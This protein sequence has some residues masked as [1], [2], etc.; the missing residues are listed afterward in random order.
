MRCVVIG[1]GGHANVVVDA[2]LEE[3][4][5]GAGKWNPIGVLDDDAS[6]RD[7][8]GDIPY[9]GAVDDLDDVEHDGV[10]LA[11]G[12][13]RTRARLYDE[14]SSRGETFATAIHPASTLA[15]SVSIGDGTLVCAGVVVNPY[16][17][18]G[19]NVILNTSC[20]VDHHCRIE[21]DVHIAP[22]V[23]LAGA[24]TIGAETLVGIGASVIPAVA[25][26]SG[27]VVGAGATVISDVPANTTVVGTPAKPVKE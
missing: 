25:I 17:E 19:T 13:N 7:G 6:K 14:L 2:M 5:S 23:N 3:L 1:A 15:S 11:L 26:G 21:R 22:G 18:V 10:F 27:C 9:L 4:R 16:A 8:V 24:V 20:S 12:D